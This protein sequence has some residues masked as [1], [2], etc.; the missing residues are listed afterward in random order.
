[1]RRLAKLD[2]SNELQLVKY[3]N[4]IKLLKPSYKNTIQSCCLSKHSITDLLNVP[5]CVGFLDANCGAVRVNE[6]SACS[7]G[8]DATEK[9]V[10]KTIYDIAS[11]ET[12][13]RITHNNKVTMQSHR[14]NMYDE[15]VSLSN[16]NDY[17]R[18][19]LQ[20]PW[21]NDENHIVGLLGF[22]ITVGEHSLAESIQSISELGLWDLTKNKSELSL[23]GMHIDNVYLSKRETECLRYVVLGKSAREIGIILQL[24]K[25][26]VE[27]Y[28]NSIK[29]KLNLHSKSE[30]IEKAIQYFCPSLLKNST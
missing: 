15:T 19:N 17:L 28:L 29:N 26:T 25:R 12:A 8:F 21:Y 27:S 20:F 30:L 1:M 10:S 18:F 22:G 24:S 4:G 3:K 13:A 14:V 7:L 2:T 6:H 9:I 11:L 23:P 5:F 16:G